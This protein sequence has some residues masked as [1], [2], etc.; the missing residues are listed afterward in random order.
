MAINL[1]LPLALTFIMGLS[2]GGGILGNN[3]GIS[4][5]PVALVAEDLPEMFKDRLA[6]GL[7][8]SGFFAATWADS[9]TADA[10]VRQGKVA[11]AIVMPRRFLAGF[12]GMED[13]ELEIWKDPA[14]SI[15]AGIIQEILV[16]AVDR[17]Q[18]GE[19]AY[20]ALWP[21]DGLAGD[22]EGQKWLRDTF[23]GDLLTIW[24]RLRSDRADNGFSKLRDQF[25]HFMDNQVVLNQAL[26]RNSIRLSVVDAS[27]TDGSPDKGNGNLFNHFLPSF[28]VFFLM[29]AIAG[30]A[31][32]LFREKK[33][34]TLQRLLLSP[35]RSLDFLLGKWLFAT[36]QGVLMLAVLFLAG[37]LLFR[38]NLGVD[39][40]SLLLAVVFCCAAAAGL[41]LLLAL[42]SPTEKFMDNL[43]TVVLLVSAMIGGNMV[44]LDYLPQWVR[45]A[46]QFTFNYW[47]TLS[48][49]DVMVHGRSLSPAGGPI[50]VL[51][52]LAL[53]FLLIDLLVVMARTRRGGL[54]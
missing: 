28:A 32:D 50:L 31:R 22:E 3:R 37:A 42:V 52:A 21:E 15:K 54:A 30:S 53:G 18:A 6:E 51:L 7:A 44:P 36:L 29:F 34:G 41:F 5:I 49:Q 16:R 14:S 9:A 40:Y 33:A 17:Y 20:R 45:W 1:V 46:G 38:V 11:A 2:F 8:D 19:A 13:V 43:T 27:S 48:F 4:A 23:Q 24:E 25:L 35:V 12:F 39:P 47:A 26:E 10:L